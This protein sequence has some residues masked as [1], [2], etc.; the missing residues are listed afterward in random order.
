MPTKRTR[1]RQAQTYLQSAGNLALA[2]ES[3]GVPP[4]LNVET[5]ARK[6]R[7]VANKREEASDADALVPATGMIVG[8]GLSMTLWSLIFL[9]WYWFRLSL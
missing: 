7:L 4:K 5:Q 6:L 8:V 3:F 2:D 9:A 1:P